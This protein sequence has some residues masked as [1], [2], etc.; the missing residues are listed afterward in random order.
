MDNTLVFLNGD[1]LPADQAKI[2]IFDRG[3][4]MGDSVYEVIPVYARNPFRLTQ[5]LERL[6]NSLDATGIANPASL[7][8][9]QAIIWQA[10]ACQAHDNQW[11]YIQI[12]RGLSLRDL[13]CP[14]TST[15]T[16]LV[17]SNP[18]HTPSSQLLATGVSAVT[19]NDNRWMRC[20][21]KTTSVLPNVLLRQK[22]VQAQAAET[23]LLRDGFLTEGTSSNVFIVK[24]GRLIAP[25]KSHLILP[26]VTYDVVLEIAQTHQMPHEVRPITEAELRQADEIWLTS[27][28]KEVLPVTL[29]D[30]KPVGA[31]VVGAYAKQMLKHYQQ[32]KRDFI[33]HV[34]D[35]VEFDEYDD[36]ES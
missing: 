3:F 2:S 27:S 31:G 23:I 8:N 25:P 5:H 24:D 13:A 18:L 20:D 7:D 26:G 19:A 6:Q 10:I 14:T 36:D 32:F 22:S 29:L 1:W 15:P 34:E 30:G 35:D 21:I 28:P 4:T 17:M 16:V 11:V 9:W 33:K 12:S